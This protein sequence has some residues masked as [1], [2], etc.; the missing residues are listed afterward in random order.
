MKNIVRTFQTRLS[1]LLQRIDHGTRAMLTSDRCPRHDDDVP[2]TP[3][4]TNATTLVAG[5]A[6]HNES[7]FQQLLRLYL[8]CH[9]VLL[10]LVF[11]GMLL[12]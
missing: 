7:V 3:S 1:N 6:K 2:P 4:H 8:N 10:R 11:L 12:L 5:P 9:H